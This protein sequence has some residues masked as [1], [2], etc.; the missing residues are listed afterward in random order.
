[1]ASFSG[2]QSEMS[3]FE[4]ILEKKDHLGNLDES[5]AL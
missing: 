2:S 4:D 1:M 3:F 5:I